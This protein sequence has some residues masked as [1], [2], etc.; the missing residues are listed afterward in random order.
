MN[1]ACELGSSY[2]AGCCLVHRPADKDYKGVDGVILLA[3][4][5]WWRSF[6]RC[7][8]GC[9]AEHHDEDLDKEQRRNINISNKA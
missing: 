5:H 4:F 2:A 3:G 8:G 1:G 6:V 9:G 7:K